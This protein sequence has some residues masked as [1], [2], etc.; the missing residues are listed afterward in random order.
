MKTQSRCS[1]QC[2]TIL[3][4]WH[5]HHHQ[6]QGSPRK[7]PKQWP[8]QWPKLWPIT[9]YNEKPKWPSNGTLDLPSGLPSGLTVAYNKLQWRINGLTSGLTSDL[10]KWW[11]FQ[12]QMKN[13]K[14]CRNFL[15]MRRREKIHKNMSMSER[16]RLFVTPYPTAF[17]FSL[18]WST[19]PPN[20]QICYVLV[21]NWSWCEEENKITVQRKWK[22]WWYSKIQKINKVLVTTFRKEE[23]KIKLSQNW[24]YKIPAYNIILV[25]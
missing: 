12:D 9:K 2:Q 25:F 17:P 8:K 18:L 3:V 15:T 20:N 16:K 6:L 10:M 13:C 1:C 4:L 24:N 11:W 22:W 23:S 14:H 5:Q 19:F 7:W 21:G